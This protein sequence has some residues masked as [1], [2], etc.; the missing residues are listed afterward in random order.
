MLLQGLSQKIPKVFFQHVWID[1][2]LH[3]SQGYCL[4]FLPTVIIHIWSIIDNR[5]TGN[6]KNGLAW[7]YC[8]TKS[9]QYVYWSF[10]PAVG[11]Q[12]ASTE[13]L[14][15]FLATNNI[16]PPCLIKYINCCVTSEKQMKNF[17]T[18]YKSYSGNESFLHL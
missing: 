1:L 2:E 6:D 18:S 12:L 15:K 5:S 8:L 16:N 17:K 13:K 11:V 14:A 7:W 9:R 4:N 3:R 10:F